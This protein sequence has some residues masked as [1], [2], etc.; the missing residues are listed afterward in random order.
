MSIERLRNFYEK[1]L[2]KEFFIT[3]IFFPELSITT[4]SFFENKLI[5]L[6]NNYSLV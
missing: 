3:G 2:K 4:T 5:T 1:I 6:G